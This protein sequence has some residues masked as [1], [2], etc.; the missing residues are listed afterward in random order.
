MSFDPSPLA[1]LSLPYA[2]IVGLITLYWLGR[3]ALQARQGKVIN[4][5]WWAVAGILALLFTSV[6]DLPALFGIAAFLLLLAEFWPLAYKKA[7]HK[8]RATWFFL[9]V[10][11]GFLGAISIVFSGI[12][13]LTTLFATFAA[14][15]VG[16]AGL[17]MVVL[18][19]EPK[20]APQPVSLGFQHR[21]QKSV[22]PEWPDLSVTLTSNG[23]YLK[24]IS[25]SDLYLAGWSPRGVNAWLQAHN[26]QGEIVKEL[27]VQQEV[28]LPIGEHD[29][30]VLVWY[31]MPASNKI[32]LFR[33][34][35]LPRSQENE[36][37]IN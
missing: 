9:A 11:F 24:N 30:G 18:F 6:L 33:A 10:F 21:W 25:N 20:L 31:A 12:L 32:L 27:L 28:V 3:V 36:R 37:L 17:L 35:W 2:G 15:L 7:E 5:A 14:L 8:P 13:S 1:S 23:T 22:Q 16:I 34:E 4:V 19:A 26:A 29:L